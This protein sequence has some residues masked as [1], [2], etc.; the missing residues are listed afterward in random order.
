VKP[1]ATLITD[2]HAAY[3][4]LSRDYRH[5]PRVVRNMAASIVLPWSH[6]V[7]SLLKRW[8]LGTYHGLRRKHV[9]AYLNEFVFRYNRRFHRHVSFETVLGIAAHRGPETYRDIVNRHASSP[10]GRPE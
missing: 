3:P 5:D 6:R 2:G 4:G 1:G 9:D 10:S 8:A 7:F